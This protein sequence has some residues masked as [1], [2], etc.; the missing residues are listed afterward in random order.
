MKQT[1]SMKISINKTLTQALKEAIAR[2]MSEM[3]DGQQPQ[4]GSANLGDVGKV[5]KRLKMLSTNRKGRDMYDDFVANEILD[6]LNP[7]DLKDILSK[8]EQ[9]TMELGHI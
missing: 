5:V 8:L 2:D 7:E 1:P 4:Y 6:K 3:E 9:I